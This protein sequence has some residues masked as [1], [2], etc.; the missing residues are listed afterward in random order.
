MDFEDPE[1]TEIE[2]AD[3]R[4]SRLLSEAQDRARMPGADLARVLAEAE[5]ELRSF[6]K[7]PSSLEFYLPA[8]RIKVLGDRSRDRASA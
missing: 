4:A 2:I 1:D 6:M 7:A 8:L 3:R 5:A